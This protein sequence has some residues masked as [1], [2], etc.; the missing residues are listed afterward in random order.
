MATTLG[1]TYRSES[2]VTRAYWFY[3]GSTLALPHAKEDK[4]AQETVARLLSLLPG[5]RSLRFRGVCVYI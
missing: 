2:W 5:S 1:P 4:I 3:E